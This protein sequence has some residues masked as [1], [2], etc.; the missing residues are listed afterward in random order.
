MKFMLLCLIRIDITHELLKSILAFNK[1][2]LV[3][4]HLKLSNKI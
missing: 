2:S 1:L 3:K 4:L